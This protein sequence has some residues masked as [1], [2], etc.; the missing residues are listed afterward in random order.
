M[1]GTL[2]QVGQG[3]L[4]T[5]LQSALGLGE[6]TG[7][8]QRSD[9]ARF[10]AQRQI[11]NQTQQQNQQIL[12][13]QYQDFLAQRGYPREQI[14]FYSD[15]VRGNAPLFGTVQQTTQPTPGVGQQLLGYGLGALGA[16]KALA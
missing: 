12:S 13:Q 14:A 3:G 8:Q 2:G 4:G 6:I 5:S 9:L 15:L 1:A 16:Y 10:E 7:A 11:A